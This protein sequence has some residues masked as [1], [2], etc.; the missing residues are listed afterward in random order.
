MAPR[1][2]RSRRRLTWDFTCL[3]N[4]ENILLL[5]DKATPVWLIGIA[6]I[7]AGIAALVSTEPG[8]AGE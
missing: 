4:A 3:V 6:L 8:A 7:L 5:D 1:G 2:A